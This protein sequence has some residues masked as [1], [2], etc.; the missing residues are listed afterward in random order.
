ME[1]IKIRNN[2]I[3]PEAEYGCVCKKCGTAFIFKIHE[4]I[5]PFWDPSD[6]RHGIISCP[7]CLNSM[8]LCECQEFASGDEKEDS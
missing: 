5:P 7:H 4:I 2:H 8:M 1:I 3:K 6:Q